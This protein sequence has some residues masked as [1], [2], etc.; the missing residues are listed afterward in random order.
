MLPVS[1]W[2]RC[3]GNGAYAAAISRIRDLSLSDFIGL[4]IRASTDNIKD[5]RAA[6]W[7]ADTVADRLWGESWKDGK[8]QGPFQT[9][10]ED[11]LAR[12]RI[13]TSERR[14]PRRKLRWT[15]V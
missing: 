13:S 10:C 4:S 8:V 2:P 6:L 9:A 14:A 7:I 5:L 3:Q 11:C 12:C 15:G 1:A